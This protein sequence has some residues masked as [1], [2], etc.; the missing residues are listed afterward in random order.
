M[1]HAAGVA[2]FLVP[3]TESGSTRIRHTFTTKTI[4]MSWVHAD[5]LASFS[6]PL[7]GQKE[8]KAPPCCTFDIITEYLPLLATNRMIGRMMDTRR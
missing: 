4:H 5:F 3:M 8:M 2:V 1:R 6:E 7:H